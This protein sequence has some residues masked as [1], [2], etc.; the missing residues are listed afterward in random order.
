MR[1]AGRAPNSRARSTAQPSTTA[2][3]RIGSS[4]LPPASFSTR[5][6]STVPSSPAWRSVSVML[7][8]RMGRGPTS[9]NTVAPWR[10]AVSTASLNSTGAR[11]F[12]H[13]Y[14]A[15]SASPATPDPV[16]VEMNGTS[17]VS[18]AM[19]PKACSTGTRSRSSRLQWNG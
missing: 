8:C 16:T 6:G 11:T 3:A 17:P 14:A 19:V 1:P 7:A 2:R 18:Q 12:C 13:Q 9:R 15:S 4:G 10:P 5:L